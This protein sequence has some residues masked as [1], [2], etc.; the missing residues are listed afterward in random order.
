MSKKIYDSLTPEEQKI[1]DEAA[2]ET[3]LY[4]REQANARTQNRID[5]LN[6]NNTEVIDLPASV[7]AEMIDL[8]QGVYDE[9]RAAVGANLV[10]ALLKEVEAA[11]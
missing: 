2:R 6:K 7:R 9:I 10:D 4:A 3:V 1:V 11:K 8:S 5:I